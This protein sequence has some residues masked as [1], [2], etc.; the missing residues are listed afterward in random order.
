MTEYSRDRFKTSALF[1]DCDGVLTDGT[2]WYDTS[3]KASKRFGSTDSNGIKV[4]LGLGIFVGVVSSD[5]SG[6]AI[7]EARCRDMGIPFFPTKGPLEK[8]TVVREQS[9]RL[10]VPME[11]CAFMGDDVADEPAMRGVGVPIA[12]SN[13]V[14]RIKSLA[15]ASETGYVTDAA[16]GH[17]AVREA[18]E[19]I[20]GREVTPDDLS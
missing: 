15:D 6:S 7:T 12:V 1:L 16:G 17:G 18:I 5:T 9:E 14:Q 4:A 8:L 2:Y 3:G 20:I 13:S 11:R 10:G 19:W